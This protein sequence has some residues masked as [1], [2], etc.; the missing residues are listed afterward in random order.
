MK[1][2]TYALFTVGLLATTN[3]WGGAKPGSKLL[4][5]QSSSSKNHT[6]LFS[7]RTPTTSAMKQKIDQ[8]RIALEQARSNY[9]DNVSEKTIGAFNK[10]LGTHNKHLTKDEISSYPEKSL[11]QITSELKLRLEKPIIPER[12]G[13][14]G[15]LIKR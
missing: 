3:C 4:S 6:S 1:L 2:T 13:I 10:A 9:K 7:P 14:T 12:N 8:S 15:S 11:K 5:R